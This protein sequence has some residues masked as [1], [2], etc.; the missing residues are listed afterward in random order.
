MARS[1]EDMN[2][3]NPYHFD[4]G[5]ISR[6]SYTYSVLGELKVRLHQPS[7]SITGMDERVTQLS[8]N[9]AVWL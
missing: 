9:K 6:Y 2:R 5:S 1:D 3:S 8:P 4:P 7:E